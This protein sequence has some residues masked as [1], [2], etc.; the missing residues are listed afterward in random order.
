MRI[1]AALAISLLAPAFADAAVPTADVARALIERVVQ[2]HSSQFN[3]EVISPDGESDVFEIE[4]R[5]GT[6]SMRCSPRV[7]SSCSAAGWKTPNAGAPT[8]QSAGSTSATL[9]SS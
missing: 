1:F 5:D 2:R 3:V 4:D 8:R 7:P 6:I 9:A